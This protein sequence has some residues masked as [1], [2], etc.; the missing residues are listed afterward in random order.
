MNYLENLVSNIIGE[1]PS[2]TDAQIVARLRTAQT[3]IIGATKKAACGKATTWLV[4]KIRAQKEY[5]G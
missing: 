4:A 5:W 3:T 1:Y 2:D